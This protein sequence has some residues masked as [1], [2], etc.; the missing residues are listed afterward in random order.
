MQFFDEVVDA[1]SV[2]FDEI[3]DF[4]AA[5]SQSASGRNTGI[6]KNLLSLAMC[7]IA[8][9]FAHS[10]KIRGGVPSGSSA[11]REEPSM[12]NTGSI[13]QEIVRRVSSPQ[14]RGSTLHLEPDQ[15][16]GIAEY[17]VQSAHRS[18]NNQ[19]FKMHLRSR[20]S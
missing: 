3:Y 14:K 5:L 2:T 11:G 16:Q 9:C 13:W 4:Q 1:R 17:R 20:G 7:W 8:R 15:H 6:S 10:P 18:S 19:Y 12:V